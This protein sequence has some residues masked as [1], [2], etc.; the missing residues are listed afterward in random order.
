M[1]P[2]ITSQQV[3]D[4]AMVICRQRNY[5]ACLALPYHRSMD[6]VQKGDKS[7]QANVIENHTDPENREQRRVVGGQ[8]RRQ[9]CMCFA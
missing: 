3:V 2:E 1:F 6:A 8:N 9:C 7:E 4:R 5:P